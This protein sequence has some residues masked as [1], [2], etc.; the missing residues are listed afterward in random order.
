MLKLTKGSLEEL[1]SSGRTSSPRAVRTDKGHRPTKSVAPTPP[2][3]SS[4]ASPF[5]IL[6]LS[7][8]LVFSRGNPKSHQSK[9]ASLSSQL[10]I[11]YCLFPLKAPNRL[12]CCTQRPCSSSPCIPKPVLAPNSA[13]SLLRS[14]QWRLQTP[15]ASP[16]DSL[17]WPSFPSNHR[18]LSLSLQFKLWPFVPTSRTDVTSRLSHQCWT[19]RTHKTRPG[20]LPPISA[21]PLQCRS[22]PHSEDQLSLAHSSTSSSGLS[23]HFLKTLRFFCPSLS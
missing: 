10:L 11:A 6:P 7:H 13:R 15:P 9:V 1:Q 22:F 12:S 2:R 14:P 17:F 16:Q 8:T 19:Y 21:P 4:S 20:V 3:R 5:W 23:A 18:H